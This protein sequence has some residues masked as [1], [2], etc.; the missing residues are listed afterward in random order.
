MALCLKES[1]SMPYI[2]SAAPTPTRGIWTVLGQ[3]GIFVCLFVC[4][5]F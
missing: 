3:D 1:V 4:F 5:Q 2:F